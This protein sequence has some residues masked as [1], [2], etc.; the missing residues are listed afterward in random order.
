MRTTLTLD[1]DVVAM[2]AEEMHRRRRPYK[3][4]VND[5]IRRGLSPGRAGKQQAT[6]RVVPHHAALLP[7]LDHAAFSQYADELADAAIVE[8]ARKAQSAGRRC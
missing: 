1:P 4:V 2:L 3:Q 7:G 6:Y 5:A 8:K